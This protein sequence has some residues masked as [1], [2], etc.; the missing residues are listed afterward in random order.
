[1]CPVLKRTYVIALFLMP[2]IPGCRNL[3]MENPEP[4]DNTKLNRLFKNSWKLFEYQ[5]NELGIYRDSTSLNAPDYHPCSVA[6]VG[7]GLVSLCIADAMGWQKDAANAALV[8]L[9]SMNGE[10]PNF[11]PARNQS[12]FFRHFIDMKTGKQAWNSEFSTIDTALLISGALF[13]KKYFKNVPE[14]AAK[15][16]MLWTSI[17]W[18]KSIADP[19]QGTIYLELDTSGIGA[20]KGVTRPFNEY[21]IV[22]WLAMNAEGNHPGQAE[23]LW[24]KHFANPD[25]LPQRSAGDYSLLT[26]NPRRFVSSFTIQFPFYFCHPCTTGEKY[27]HY[28]QKAANADRARFSGW[29]KPHAW[30]HGAGQAPEGYRAHNLDKNPNQVVSPHIVA[31]FIPAL[32]EAKADIESLLYDNRA[33]Y[34]TPVGQLLWRFSLK[35]KTWR[36][37][38]IQGIDY[39][40]ML[41]GLAALPE[42]LGVEFFAKNNDFDFPE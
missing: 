2:F 10:H 3:Q 41:L 4:T 11:K 36:A 29:A 32:P 39:S 23:R 40:S 15:A 8:T 17:D 24:Q 38:V 27:K 9:K 12:G 25:T 16:D 19:M 6:N 26:D 37:N 34:D 31:G 42:H 7:M 21:M 13:C 14:I 33:L 30:G 22:A 28:F 20:G 5:R 1:M 18:S 35:D